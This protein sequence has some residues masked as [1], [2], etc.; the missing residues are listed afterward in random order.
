MNAIM[1]DGI[2]KCYEPMF[3]YNVN[4]DFCDIC[5]GEVIIDENYEY[6]CSPC[7]DNTFYHNYLCY[8]CHPLCGTCDSHI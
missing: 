6:V 1:I 7:P 3:F 8:A 2:C 5:V 4:G